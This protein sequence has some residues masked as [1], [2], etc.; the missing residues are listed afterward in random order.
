VSYRIG[1]DV[2]GTFTD[3]VLVRPDGE[4]R[5]AKSAT[6]PGDESLGVMNGIRA[7]A[8]AEGL[9]PSGLLTRCERIVHSTTTADNTLI[10]MNGALCGLIT[11]AGHRDQIE[12]RRGFKEE[13]WDPAFPA[14]KPIAQRRRRFGVPERLDFEGKVVVPLDE[15]AVRR[16]ALRL[17]KLGV[18]SVAVVLLF[19]FLEPAHERRVRAIL[20]DEL[21][22]VRISL[23]HEVMP[24]APE[25]ERTSTTLVEAYV[26]PRLERYLTR[27]Q[28]AL[29]ASGYGR[30]LLIMQSSGGIMTTKTLSKRAVASLSSGPTAGV[31]AACAIAS[32]AGEEDFV[33]IDM[34]GTSYE[35]CLVRGGQPT[36]SSAW[37]WRQRYLIGLPMVKL[38]SIG[39]GGGSIA[40]VEAGALRV[41]PESAGAEPGPICY[42]RGGREPTVTDANLVLG[43]LNPEALC[44]G[45]L[46]LSAVGVREAILEKIARPLGL[47]LVEAAEAIFRIVNA[48]M[49][50]AIRRVSSQA[51]TDPRGLAMLVYGGNGPLHAGR[52]AE[53]LGMHRIVVPRNSPAFSALGLLLSDYVFDAQRACIAPADAAEPGPINQRLDAMEAQALAEFA[54]AGLGPESVT[55]HR[56]VQI[57][58][59]GQTFDTSVPATLTEGRLGAEDLASTVARFHDLHQKLHGFASPEQS[60]LIRAVRLQ[61]IGATD[62]PELRELPKAT[63][64]PSGALTGRRAARFEGRFVDTP[65]YDGAKLTHGHVIEGPAIVEETFTTLVVYPGQVAELD[66]YGSYRVAL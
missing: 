59:P 15:A 39:A 14:P 9:T 27:L 19:S 28:E 36:V 50:N 3:F 1:M 37:N 49:A 42:G 33:A 6:T 66:R 41:G 32:N 61:A 5:L 55:F 16:A 64:G 13:I 38:H 43:Y 54:V 8:A 60:P 12:L 31:M 24:A 63:T 62:K 17:R 65:V 25:F 58:Y 40:R 21:P 20:E 23:S 35:A 51:G 34:G 57:T 22:G 7:L 52:Q 56:F 53:E 10:Q 18:E 47:D 45:A 48:N 46:A 44:G 29:R 26:G 30:E 11:S 2:G 4:L